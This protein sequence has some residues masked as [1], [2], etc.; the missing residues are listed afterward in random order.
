MN[1]V[2]FFLSGAVA[3]LLLASALVGFIP[4]HFGSK[5]TVKSIHKDYI[6]TSANFRINC[7]VQSYHVGDTLVLITPK[8]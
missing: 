7:N 4:M 8:N 1:S 5:Q 3:A 6:I 2:N